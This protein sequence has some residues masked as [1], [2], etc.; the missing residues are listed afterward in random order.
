VLEPH[1]LVDVPLPAGFF[2]N[3][4]VVSAK[5]PPERAAA[6]FDPPLAQLC[7]RLDQGQVWPLS[8]HSQYLGRGL[9]QWRNASA[10]RLRAALLFSPQ[11]CSHFTAEATLTSKRPA[12]SRR[13]APASTASITR[14]RRS[15]E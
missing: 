14:S 3:G 10:A 5:K 13:D 12:A 4:D 2:F 1:P 6:G 11:R 8:D 9:F 7:N 15:P